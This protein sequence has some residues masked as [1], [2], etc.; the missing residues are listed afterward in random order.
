M[1]SIVKAPVGF[2]QL[3]IA[4]REGVSLL[5]DCA[6]LHSVALLDLV[7][8]AHIQASPKKRCQY[9][10]GLENWNKLLCMKIVKNKTLLGM[11]KDV[12]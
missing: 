10:N 4:L 8:T 7:L 1:D 11:K 3:D 5:D 9:V 6:Q 12:I 2:L